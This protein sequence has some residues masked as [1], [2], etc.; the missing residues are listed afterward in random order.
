MGLGWRCTDTNSGVAGSVRHRRYD[1]AAKLEGARF[2]ATC[3]FV[4][5]GQDVLFSRAP[6]GACLEGH[7]YNHL[8]NKVVVWN[9]NIGTK[10]QED[11][12]TTY[13]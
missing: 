10:S 8:S 4:S 12:C 9:M 13:M 6:G 2:H 3:C 1:N 5:H 7:A 11:V